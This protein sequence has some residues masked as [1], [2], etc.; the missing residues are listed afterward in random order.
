MPTA[1]AKPPATMTAD[2]FIAWVL[3]GGTKGRRYQLVDGEVRAMSPAGTTHGTIQATLAGILMRH[4]D[5]PG[6]R[7]RVVTEPA[8]AT[9]IRA[10]HNIRVPDLGV[11]CVPDAKGEVALP[12]PILLIEILSPGNPKNTWDNVWAYTSIPT[13][14]EI[15]VVHG[16]RMEAELLRRQADGTWP[17]EPLAI[18][19]DD[20][21]E[22]ASIGLSA[23]LR[24][25]YAK[26]HLAA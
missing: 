12:D 10:R 3:E 20:P 25:A 24:V 8:V 23:P 5:I 7:C 13:V 4:L 6:S 16:S 14:A 9:R 22:L 11:T 2:A 19:P 18:G 15:L 1:N 21:L 17:A 26:T